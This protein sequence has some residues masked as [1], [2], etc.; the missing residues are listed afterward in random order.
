MP[1]GEK[2]NEELR[3]RVDG[4]FFCAGAERVFLKMVTYGPFPK[5]TPEVL[6]DHDE[7]MR[8]IADAG[9]NAIRVYEEPGHTLLDAAQKAGLWVFVGL[10]WEYHRDFVSDTAIYSTAQV[11]MKEGLKSWGTHPALAGV[12]VAN[13]IPSDI[14]RWMGVT[15]VKQALEQLINLGRSICPHL[16]FAYAN[17]PTTEYEEPDN[18]DF[19]AMNVYL[20]NR[21]D[22][23]RYL[24]RLHNVAGD[25]PV[26]LS[27]FGLDTFRQGEQ[28]QSDALLWYVDESVCAGM[29]GVTI[30]AWS[31]HWSRGGLVIDE[32]SFGLFDRRGQAK[33]S[34]LPLRDKL[35]GIDSPGDGIELS[36]SPVFSVVVCTH[37]GA[38]RIGAC[39]R[40]L[41]NLDYPDFEI[42]VVDDGSSDD[43]AE[44]VRGFSDVRLIESE[45]EGL[46]AARNRGAREAQGDIIAYT[47]DD[48]RPDRQWLWWLAK[49]FNQGAGMP[50]VVL[51][52]LR[53]PKAQMMAVLVSSMRL[54]WLRHK[55]LL[56]MCC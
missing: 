29:A 54:W 27:E 49:A 11:M 32:W 40:A 4:K 34:L 21:D 42:L 31:D 56:L 51:I 48:C 18:A 24:A 38:A 20:E 7:Q 23:A 16:L 28:A 41:Q 15:R 12:F 50:V 46:G 14:V 47:D 13:E 8:R 5:P 39:L 3:L 52:W 45:H 44:I 37:N 22:F 17:Y 26:L 25:R 30:Y 53:V 35:A 43:T 55:E 10:N 19:T 2:R 36:E 1:T 33:L 6:A 9:F